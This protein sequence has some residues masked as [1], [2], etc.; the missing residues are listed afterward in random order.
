M[1]E[2]V[3]FLKALGAVSQSEQAL[4]SGAR[5][6]AHRIEESGGR[7]I[8]GDLSRGES[9]TLRLNGPFAGDVVIRPDGTASIRF[10]EVPLEFGR[11]LFEAIGAD[12]SAERSRPA[13]I[14]LPERS[15]RPRGPLPGRS[16]GEG[17]G[18]PTG[19]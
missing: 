12:I 1:P 4:A 13:P 10:Q 6:L 9:A 18:R 7:L 11:K 17:G 2:A 3:A 5:D 14:G 8:E 19:F 15:V 16:G